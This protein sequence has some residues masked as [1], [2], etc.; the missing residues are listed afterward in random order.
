VR[1][2]VISDVHSNV[3]ALDAM[4][5]ALRPFD[6]VWHMGDVVGYGPQ[7]V[8]AIERLAAVQATSVLGN[9]DAAVLGTISSGWFN[10]DARAAIEWTADR[11]TPAARHW[12]ASLRET[13][14]LHDFTLVHGSPR[15]PLF[16][17]VMSPETARPSIEL[18]MSLYGAVGHTHIPLL[19]RIDGEDTE[20]ILA[21]DGL[22]V[23]L[24]E[25]RLIV[26][27]GSVGQPRDGDSRASAILLD[28]EA[29][30]LTWRRASYAVEE[31]QAA[32]RTA[33][34]PRRLIERLSHGR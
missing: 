14:V 8:E 28:T 20:A 16:E 12:L 5:D 10:N 22:T 34:L 9:H 17:Y 15:E 19:F 18:L 13:V 31:V 30:T 2:A 6:A 27:P 23:E 7:P 32:M 26:N 11:L 24:D 4:L 1:I 25:R 3:A 33:K 21:E 29:R